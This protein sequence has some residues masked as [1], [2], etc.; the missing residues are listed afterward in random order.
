MS[1]N[2]ILVTDIAKALSLHRDVNPNT[3]DDEDLTV[4]SS[5]R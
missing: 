2:D 1:N 5:I 3:L 4:L